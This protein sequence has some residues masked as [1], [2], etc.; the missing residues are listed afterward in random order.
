MPPTLSL[1]HG[2]LYASTRTRAKASCATGVKPPL[3]AR[4]VG[5]KIGLERIKLTAQILD[6]VLKK[7]A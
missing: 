6:V 2:V 4:P 3:S 1:L 5:G 7:V